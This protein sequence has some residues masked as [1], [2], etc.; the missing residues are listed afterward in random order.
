MRI[1]KG[2]VLMKSTKNKIWFVL[3]VLLCLIAFNSS[4]SINI[5][6][7]PIHIRISDHATLL[8]TNKQTKNLKE[9][10]CLTRNIYYEARGES[11]EG[12]LAVAQ[13]TL[14]RVDSNLFPNSICGVINER[15]RV[16]TEMVCQFSWRCE[17][18]TN[19]KLVVSK[20]NPIYKLAIEAIMTHHVMT[21]VTH[22]TYWFHAYYVKPKWRKSKLKVAKIDD[23][24]FYKKK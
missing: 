7:E 18:S 15:Y 20:N 13:V 6:L 14:N 5:N 16:G 3:L 9:L 8:L 17:Q 19:Q 24:I 4:N 2:D 1:K 22:D 12:Q 21:V 23:H 10:D 11:R